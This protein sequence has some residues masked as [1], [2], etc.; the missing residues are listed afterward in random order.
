MG[1][2]AKVFDVLGRQAGTR[3][4]VEEAARDEE[5]SRSSGRHVG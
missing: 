3:E 2:G 1:D 4:E 5:E